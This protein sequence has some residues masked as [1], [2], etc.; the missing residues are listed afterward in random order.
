MGNGL[1]GGPSHIRL[2]SADRR[3]AHFPHTSA[4]GR[5]PYWTMSTLAQPSWASASSPAWFW[6][7]TAHL[8]KRNGQSISAEVGV[9]FR[10]GDWGNGHFRGGEGRG[11]RVCL[12][13]RGKTATL[14][15]AYLA[16]QQ[17]GGR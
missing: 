16:R 2:W 17:V 14:S 8:S 3:R 11:V 1:A 4:Q 12:R 7:E 9:E 5:V 13:G 10:S 6:H 15:G